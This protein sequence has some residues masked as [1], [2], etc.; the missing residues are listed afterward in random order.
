VLFDV[1]SPAAELWVEGHVDPDA[2]WFGGALVV[3]HRFAGDLASAIHAEGLRVE[4]LR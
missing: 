2:Q 1:V 4:V 3:E